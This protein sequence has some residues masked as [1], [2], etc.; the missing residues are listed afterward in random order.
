MSKSRDYSYEELIK[1]IYPDSAGE[2]SKLPSGAQQ[3]EF[4]IPDS[5]RSWESAQEKFFAEYVKNKAG[6][7]SRCECGSS[8]VGS[9][10]HSDYCPLYS[11][12]N[13]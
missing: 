4:E 5:H 1:V 10:A 13:V 9:S 2:Q 6:Y 3:L 11:K 8:A 12:D 7:K